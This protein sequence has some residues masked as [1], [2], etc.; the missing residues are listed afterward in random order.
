MDFFTGFFLDQEAENVKITGAEHSLRVAPLRQFQTFQEALP[1]LK[2]Q[3]DPQK[4]ALAEKNTNGEREYFY[5]LESFIQVQSDSSSFFFFDNH[6]HALFFRAE[7]L[8]QHP[9]NYS[10]IHLDQ[11]SDMNPCDKKIQQTD[12]KSR[13]SFA[14]NKTHVGNFIQPALQ[15]GLISSVELVLTEY[16]LKEIV[17]QL[18]E[19]YL[20]DID[21]DFRAPEMGYRFQDHLSYLRVLLQHAKAVTVATSPYFLDQWLAL[22][23]IKQLFSEF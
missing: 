13:F 15:N 10:V 18:P 17:S 12:L 23:M 2:I 1:F 6:N 4:P 16:R 11:H 22:K 7:Y 3:D 21:L 14:E 8:A 19:S 9:W 20:L 5:G